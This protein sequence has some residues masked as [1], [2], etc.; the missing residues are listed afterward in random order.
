MLIHDTDPQCLW[1]TLRISPGSADLTL[2]LR[3]LI[4]I[5]QRNCFQRWDQNRCDFIMG[6]GNFKLSVL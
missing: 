3:N 6:I 5:A 2:G 1:E 4:F